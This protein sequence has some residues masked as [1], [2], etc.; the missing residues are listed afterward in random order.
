MGAHELA[1]R[2]ESATGPD[3]RL[4]C[5]IEAAIGKLKGEFRVVGAPTYDPER[6]FSGQE[7]M[8]WIGYDLLNVGPHHTASI[9][10]AL[11][12]VPEGWRWI[13]REACPDKGNPNERGFF[14]RLETRDFESVTW[15]KGECWITDIE[16]GQETFCWAS[17]PALALC[18]SALRAHAALVD[19]HPEGGDVKQGPFMSGAVGEA[20]TPKGEAQ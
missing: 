16:A 12:L 17:T 14:A 6:Y 4:D 10:S 5:E 13:M 2:C 19:T 8:D 18:A 7:G 3:R 20:E 1:A 15:G 11:A 9:D